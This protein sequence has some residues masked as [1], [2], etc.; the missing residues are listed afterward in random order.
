MVHDSSI[1]YVIIAD[2]CLLRAAGSFLL[3]G[4]EGK[5]H[6]PAL[7]GKKCA[8]ARDEAEKSVYWKNCP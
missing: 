4:K 6:N 7:S 8:L 2:Y 3:C 5:F 1:T